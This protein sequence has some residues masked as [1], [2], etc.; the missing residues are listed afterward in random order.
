VATVSK[1]L[2]FEI[3]RRDNHACRYCGAQAPGVKLVIDA[4]IPEALGGSHK[5]PANLVTAC[6]PCNSGKTSTAPGAPLVADV[7]QDA[8]RWSQAMAASSAEMLARA[9][10]HVDAQEHFA[11]SWKR[12]GSATSG[13]RR[14]P[15]PMDADWRQF[16][17]KILS[18]GLPLSELE[19]CIDIAMARK[20]VPEDRVFRYMAG[21][22]WNK[23]TELQARAKEILDEEEADPSPEWTVDLACEWI[24]RQC[25]PDE[26]KRARKRSI[27]INDGE[28]VGLDS[29]LWFLVS[30]LICERN[31][32]SEVLRELLLA[33]PSEIGSREIARHEGAYR[34]EYQRLTSAAQW[35][36]EHM[37]LARARQEMAAMP[38]GEYE[39][40]V[41][42]ARDE[43]ADFA[44]HLSESF[45]VIDGA[46]LARAALAGGGA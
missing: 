39:M 25:S 22:A 45:Y 42:M 12:F 35:A 43:N 2:R 30:D 17:D 36:A 34:D 21:V 7:A 29:V 40:W 28:A 20:T 41:Q 44:E 9:S 24:L 19:D 26:V 11:K 32:L 15:L 5:D 18:A 6:E 31:S 46:R 27:E 38:R 14:K 10:E 1:R 13:T 37:L 4:V 3:L 23:V 16:V 33:L 8:F